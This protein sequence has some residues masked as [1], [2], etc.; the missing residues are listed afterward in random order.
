MYAGHVVLSK[1]NFNFTF[2]SPFSKKKHWKLY[3]S[4]QM[5]VGLDFYFGVTVVTFRGPLF[6]IKLYDFI[7]QT[8]ASNFLFDFEFTTNKF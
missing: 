5:K 8:L 3:N 2:K 6:V 4:R 7:I 1:T